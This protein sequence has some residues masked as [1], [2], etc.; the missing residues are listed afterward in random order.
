MSEKHRGAA[1]AAFLLAVCPLAAQPQ[2]QPKQPPQPMSF[3]VTSTGV[4]NGA[5]LGGL[6]GADAH[7]QKL[8]EGAGA[9]NRTW[10]GA[11]QN[12]SGSED[13][14]VAVTIRFLD[15]NN[16]PVG[17]VRGQVERLAPGESLPLQGPLPKTAARMQ[18]YSVQRR[19]GPDN[20][21]RLLGPYRPW[22]FGVLQNPEKHDFAK[23]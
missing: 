11:F 3:F 1:V 12:A 17:E 18:V 14:E 23:R 5:N 6:A 2:G 19:T 15:N 4:G 22:E 16:G 7:C 9:G 13:R 20:L 8:A 10:Y 21:G